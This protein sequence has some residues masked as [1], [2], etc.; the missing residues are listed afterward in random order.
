MDQF[1]VR[2]EKPFQLMESKK[3]L[4]LDYIRQLP[5]EKYLQQPDKSTWSIGQ[6]A[7]HLYLSEK[8]SLAYLKKKLSYPDTIPPYSIKS[9][10]SMIVYKLFFK[11]LKA[12]APKGI[13]MWEG[14]DILLPEELD[15]KWSDLRR[16]LFEF[17]KE[18]YPAFKTHLVYNHP[19]AGR[20]TFTQTLY[21][22]ADHIDHH[23]KQIRKI[24]Q[25]LK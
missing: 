23:F 11:F 5:P 8:L 14:Q 10:W 6:A 22:F 18:K 25:R 7:N 1:Q 2:I 3:K 17:L 20:L 13:N 16:E 15:S 21:F 24:E 12:K 19:F 4:L 9:R